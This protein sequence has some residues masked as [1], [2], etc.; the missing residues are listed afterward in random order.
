MHNF[1]DDDDDDDDD[2]YNGMLIY[3]GLLFGAVG[4]ACVYRCERRA[5]QVSR[6]DTLVD[7]QHILDG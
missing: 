3:T 6:Q 5:N 7:Y 1:Q 4:L 2:A